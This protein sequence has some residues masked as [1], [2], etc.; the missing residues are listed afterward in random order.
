VRPGRLLDVGCGTGGFV[1]IAKDAGWEAFGVELSE[2]AA[3]CAVERGVQVRAGTLEEQHFPPDYFDVVTLWDVLEHLPDPSKELME[4]YR[5][6]KL[7]GFVVIRVPNTGIQLLKVYLFDDLL[8]INRIGLQANLHLSH[9]VSATLRALLKSCG[10]EVFREE[11]GV[12]EDK[13][14]RRGIPLRFKDWYCRLADV[15]CNLTSIQLG[16]T[17]VQYGRKLSQNRGSAAP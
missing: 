5:I 7:D 6:L 11:A 12:S 14:Y 16:P 8:R 13:V 2:S 1:K 17:L 9:F 4:I 15:L 3:N 10:F